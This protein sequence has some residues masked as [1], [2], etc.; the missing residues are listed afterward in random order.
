[1]FVIPTV[2]RWLNQDS[3]PG[4]FMVQASTVTIGYRGVT[5]YKKGV[6]VVVTG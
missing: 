1:M 5:S 3:N 2:D 6:Q 4:P